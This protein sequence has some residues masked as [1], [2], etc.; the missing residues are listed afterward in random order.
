MLVLPTI[1]VCVLLEAFAPSSLAQERVEPDRSVDNHALFVA[2][3]SMYGIDPDLLAAIASVESGGRPCA[4]SSKGALGL[5]QLMPATA[6][7]FGVADPCDPVE[8]ALGAARFIRYLSEL[9]V[10]SGHRSISL[11][12]V[13]AAYNA[14]PRAVAEFSG[15]PPYRETLQYV[16]DVLFTYLLSDGTGGL[17]TLSVKP[18]EQPRCDRAARRV[19][20]LEQLAGIRRARTQAELR[21]TPTN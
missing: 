4:V 12:E 1:L 11:P 7:H 5:M 20:P 10:S 14:G 13:V 21:R 9:Q 6:Q 17:G 19:D 3:G 15:I 8:S 2:V 18:R 16:R